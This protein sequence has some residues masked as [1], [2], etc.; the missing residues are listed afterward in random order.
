MATEKV[1]GKHPVEDLLYDRLVDAIIDKHLRP[2]QHLNEVKLAERF[3]VPRSRVRRVLERLRDEDV[4]VFELNRGAFVSRP[5]TKEAHNVFETRRHLEDL[6]VRL[7]CERATPEDIALLRENLRDERE[8][9]AAMRSDVNRVA[10]NFHFAIARISGNGVLEKM[11]A[12]LIRRCV[13]VQSVYEKKSGILC[14][15]EEHGSLIDC[16]EK[17]DP[18]GAA[19]LMAHHFDH[20]ISSL[21]LTEARRAEIDSFEFI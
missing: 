10:A 21:D 8:A 20:I 14:L 1:R 19:H 5:T 3:D 18:E 4:V 13:L 2:G 6:V 16:I 15:S 17:N 9:F 7:A 12:Q 11:V